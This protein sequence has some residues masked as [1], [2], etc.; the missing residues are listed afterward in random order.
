MVGGGSRKDK[1]SLMIS[2]TN[3]FAALD[4]L[5]KKKK[6]D[7]KSEGKSSKGSES[8][9]EPQVFWAPAP[10]NVKSWADVD[11]DDDYY[12]TT[13]PPQSV[14]NVPQPHSNVPKHESFEDSESEDMLDEGDD[15]VEEEHD[16]EPD[17]SMKPEPELQKHNEVPAAPKEAERHL[18]KKERKKKE[19]AELDA[20]LADFGV[21]QK[22]SIGQDESQ[23][24]NVELCAILFSRLNILGVKVIGRTWH[25]LPL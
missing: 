19:L 5:K 8:E 12:A 7:K 14:W 11:D 20:L 25:A 4:S 15:D 24:N 2:N 22:E 23:G 1:G 13:A 10:L 16:P 6:S 21:T 18:S 3:V 9:S 17:Y